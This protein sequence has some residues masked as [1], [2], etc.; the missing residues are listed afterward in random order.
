METEE[1]QTEIAK[2]TWYHSIPLDEGIVTPG[3]DNS[4]LR[5]PKIHLPQDLRGKSVLDVGAWDGFFSFEAERRGAERVLAT[6][7]F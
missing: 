4:S 7:S 1:L 5:L 6:E 3:V 2:V